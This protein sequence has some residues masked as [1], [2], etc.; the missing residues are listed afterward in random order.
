MLVI[1]FGNTL[2]EEITKCILNNGI[3]VLVKEEHL[4]SLV[5]LEVLVRCGPVY[6]TDDVA[7]ISH[8]I[9]HIIYRNID[10]TK[11]KELGGEIDAITEYGNTH[12]GITLPAIYFSTAVDIIYKAIISPSFDEEK[13]ESERDVVIEELRLTNDNPFEF[14][15]QHLMKTAF[16]KHPYRRPIGGYETVVRFLKKRDIEK[17]YRKY[18]TPKRMIITVIGNIDKNKAISKIEKVF[19]DFKRNDFPESSQEKEPEQQQFR[20]SLIK[21]EIDETYMQMGFH[22]PHNTH[23]DIYPLKILAYLVGGGKSSRFYRELKENLFLITSIHTKIFSDKDSGL[24]IINTTLNSKNIEDAQIAILREIEKLKQFSITNRELEKAR[25][26]LKASYLFCQE[27]IEKSTTTLGYFEYLDDYTLAE[28]YYSN[29]Y[30]VSKVD[31]KEVAKKYLN[32]SNCSLII[33]A[34][35]MDVIPQ[36]KFEPNQLKNLLKEKVDNEIKIIINEKVKRPQSITKKMLKNGITIL[37]ME[38]HILPIISIAVYLKGGILYENEKN[39]GITNLLQRI[40]IRGTRKRTAKEIAAEIESLGTRIHPF[41]GKDTFG[42]FIEMLSEDFD[43]VIDLLT[44]IIKN[45]SFNINQIKSEKKY[46]HTYIRMKRNRL[47]NYTIATL[48][49]LIYYGHPYRMSIL[50]TPKSISGLTT[51]ELEQWYG[52]FYVPNNMV[53]AIV[54][55]VQTDEVFMKVKRNLGDLKSRSN[56]FL[57][58]SQMEALKPLR[59]IEEQRKKNTE[60]LAIGFPGP[61]ITNKDDYYPMEVLQ[62]SFNLSK[63]LREK[64]GLSYEYFS[65]LDANTH[66]GSFKIYVRASPGKIEEVKAILLREL[67]NIEN[68]GITEGELD[69][70]K[71]E[72]I[73]EYQMKLERRLT[74]AK[75]YAYNE[76][77]GLGYQEIEQYPKMIKKVTQNDIKRVLKKYFNFED[78]FSVII[79]VSPS[80]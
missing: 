32:L 47:R 23:K 60:T 48:D 27:K 13:L 56:P 30:N 73:G 33:Y 11:I 28:K 77:I 24:F 44:D 10:N 29:L 65:L 78:Y 42:Y 67:Q 20:Y 54:G 17:Y 62:T 76:I 59:K 71:R 49:S 4:V 75:L 38:N 50:G 46:I 55:D 36:E 6:E 15:S 8:F 2:A 5:S 45:P 7:G 18:Y 22:I 72:L 69:I 64:R 43:R 40:M 14:S 19:S 70:T 9:E 37:V 58:T 63:I 16:K 1:T 80:E 31:I 41:T 26:T 35:E 3:T 34:P 57:N 61:P 52:I 74:Q 66:K 79:K 39:N 25:R 53:I 51:A 68:N 12:Y 21:G